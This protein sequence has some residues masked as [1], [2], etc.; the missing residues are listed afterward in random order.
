G[1]PA[2]PP[3][4]ARAR[5]PKR[6]DGRARRRMTARR[7]DRSKAWPPAGSFPSSRCENKGPASARKRRPSPQSRSQ[8]RAP[9]RDRQRRGLRPPWRTTSDGS[10]DCLLFA[11]LPKMFYAA[12]T[13]ITLLAIGN[14]GASVA[15]KLHAA[16]SR[17]SSKSIFAKGSGISR[18]G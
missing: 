3:I 5:R 15:F 11:V 9:R 14:H 4:A 6:E 7:N 8:N 17:L 13:R 18:Q 2:P 1:S 10:R 12:V 16:R